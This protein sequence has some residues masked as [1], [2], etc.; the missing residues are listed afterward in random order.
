MVSHPEHTRIFLLSINNTGTLIV[1]I[2]VHS[3]FLS[4]R[5]M[6]DTDKVR[7]LFIHSIPF[8]DNYHVG[9]H[10][11]E[12]GAWQRG[13]AIICSTV[14]QSTCIGFGTER[15]GGGLGGA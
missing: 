11:G 8:I 5:T 2:G 3:R 15:K 10:K 12:K 13:K 4:S 14:L 9:I 1:D 6:T 7:N